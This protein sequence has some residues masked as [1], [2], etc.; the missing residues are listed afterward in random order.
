ML[1]TVTIKNKLTNTEHKFDEWFGIEECFDRSKETFDLIVKALEVEDPD[2]YESVDELLEYFDIDLE[3][4]LEVIE[5]KDFCIEVDSSKATYAE[6]CELYE[7]DVE[8]EKIKAY[9]EY[10]GYMN[11]G[12]ILYVNWDDV[13][14]YKDVDTNTELGYYMV[15]DVL[16]GVSELTKEE[17]ELYF[18]YEAYGRDYAINGGSFTSE[19][20][21][22][23]R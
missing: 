22:E 3:Q 15:D 18:D 19:G 10:Q 23:V 8:I 2:L 20:F 16:G 4:Y 14:L 1:F 7:L 21:I 12:D 9:K 11:V 17:L 13:Y 6:I 5:L